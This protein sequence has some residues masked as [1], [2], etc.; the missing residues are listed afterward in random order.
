MP[1]LTN[2]MLSE[3]PFAHHCGPSTQQW[4][5]LRRCSILTALKHVYCFSSVKQKPLKQGTHMIWLQMEFNLYSSEHERE[6]VFLE[7]FFT[8][9][10]LAFL[11]QQGLK[12]ANTNLCLSLSAS[13]ASVID[14]DSS[15]GKDFLLPLPSP[16]EDW[17][18]ILPSHSTVLGT[19]KSRGAAGQGVMVM[20]Q[21]DVCF[22]SRVGSSSMCLHPG[23]R[24]PGKV[25]W[26]FSRTAVTGPQ[27]GWL[28]QQKC[29]V[30]Q[31]WKLGV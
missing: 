7:N 3:G 22:G 18:N 10:K 9:Q 14:S 31:L 29:I 28:K 24:L 19:G 1:T 25:L 16:S 11:K 30:S 6:L 8:K 17:S 15:A 27:T 12:G 2:C 21:P 26:P 13:S 20:A 23:E 5:A 4:L